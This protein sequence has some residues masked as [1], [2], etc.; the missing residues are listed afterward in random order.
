MCVGSAL[1]VAPRSVPRGI[2]WT[3]HGVWEL[4]FTV[5]VYAI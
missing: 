5:R 3:V 1:P 4:F 2:P